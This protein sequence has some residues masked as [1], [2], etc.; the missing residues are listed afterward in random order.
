MGYAHNV[1]N[2]YTSIG[3]TN[4]YYDAVGNLAV[5]QNGYQHF[6]DYEN[7]LQEI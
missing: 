7:R 4:V 1:A 3:G 2:E 5:D 6:Y